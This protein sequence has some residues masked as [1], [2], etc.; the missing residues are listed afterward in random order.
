MLEGTASV[1]GQELCRRDG[2][3]VWNT[4]NVSVKAE[5]DSKILLMEVPMSI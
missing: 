1:Q 2:F 3:G 4:S 5:K